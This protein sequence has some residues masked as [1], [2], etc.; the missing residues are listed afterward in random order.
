MTIKVKEVLHI[1]CNMELQQTTFWGNVSSTRLEVIV[2]LQKIA[3]NIAVFLST[4]LSKQSLCVKQ[5]EDAESW[6]RQTCK[7]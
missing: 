6:S 7:L 3:H 4:A 5:D 2:L 1:S